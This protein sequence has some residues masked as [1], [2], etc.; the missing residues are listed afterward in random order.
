MNNDNIEDLL[1]QYGDNL[2]QQQRA[3][4][5]VKGMARRAAVVRTCSVCVV[6]FVGLLVGLRHT[7]PSQPL[8]AATETAQD[9]TSATL[10]TEQTHAQPS[11]SREVSKK[12]MLAAVPDSEPESDPIPLSSDLDVP[13]PSHPTPKTDVRLEEPSATPDELLWERPRLYDV[14]I[15][16]NDVTWKDESG[17]RLRFSFAIGGSVMG[18]NDLYAHRSEFPIAEDGIGINSIT[19]AEPSDIQYATPSGSYSV[20]AAVT[21]ALVQS[22]KRDLNLGVGLDGSSIQSEVVSGE[23]RDGA[24]VWVG[25]SSESTHVLYLN[26]PLSYRIHPRGADR[27]GW[28]CGISPARQL[29]AFNE[30]PA[31]SINPWKLTLGFGIVLPRGAVRSISLTANLLSTYEYHRMHEFGISLGF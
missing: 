19:D 20:Q 7:Q 17:S 31:V 30:P 26:T 14:D 22:E 28:Q 5:K 25:R 13:P 29:F 4:A 2:R 9:A 15:A 18:G 11:D 21:Y 23:Y 10:V 12:P 27:L 24:Y 3:V 16:P 6:L 8:V 1:N